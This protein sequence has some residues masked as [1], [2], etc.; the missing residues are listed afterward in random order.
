ML[1]VARGRKEEMCLLICVFIVALQRLVH[2][3]QT[4]ETLKSL[5]GTTNKNSV[6]KIKSCHCENGL[7]S[8]NADVKNS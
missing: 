7:D 3:L 1:V 8:N 6:K 5:S 2:S 4:V